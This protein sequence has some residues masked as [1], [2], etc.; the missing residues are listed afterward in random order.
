VTAA[1]TLHDYELS[2][3]AYKARL[4]MRLL[5]VPFASVPID[6]YPGGE[7]RSDVF[8]TLN[9]RGTLPVL[10]DGEVT[11]AGAEAVLIHLAER[12]DPAGHWL[13][14]AG[15]ARAETF[16]WL[17]F[18]GQ[19]LAAADAARIEAML[20][21]APPYP[22]ATKRARDAFRVIEDRLVR[23]GFAAAAFLTG[24]EPTIAD[25]ACFPA[26]ALAI[27][28]GEALEDYPKIRA[29]TRRIR[30]LPGFVAMPGIPEFV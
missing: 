10:L 12:Y 4:M 11:A 9:P 22:D 18:S 30:G 8:L 13:P 26:A 16:G 15:Q 28:F 21:I 1:I 25:I 7:H 23:Q 5:S 14:R 19:E 17:A 20:G 2:A 29:W 6:L 27:D 3:D 24:A